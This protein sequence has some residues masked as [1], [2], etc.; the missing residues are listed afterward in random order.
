MDPI[1]DQLAS[2]EAD[3]S[4]WFVNS[5]GAEAWAT[6]R[7]LG[8]H[9]VSF[10]LIST[11][12]LLRT[13]EVVK[14]FRIKLGQGIAYS[15]RATTTSVTHAGP[16]MIC[17][18]ALEEPMAGPRPDDL[19][20]AEGRGA[21]AFDAFIRGWQ[22]YYHIEPSFKVVVADLQTMLTDMEVWLS[23]L[24]LGFGETSVRPPDSA[25]DNLGRELG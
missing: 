14:E 10:E 7:H 3:N 16:R 12:G 4:I 17:S 25:L 20:G 1:P 6:L 13:S 23:S 9:E 24:E 8:R 2:F 22:K 5:D 19:I 15:G 11:D 18:V 21:S